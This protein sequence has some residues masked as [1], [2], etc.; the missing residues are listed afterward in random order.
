MPLFF[1]LRFE[2]E[3]IDFRIFHF[4]HIYFVFFLKASALRYSSLRFPIIITTFIL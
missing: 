4:Q 3:L 2:T 1:S